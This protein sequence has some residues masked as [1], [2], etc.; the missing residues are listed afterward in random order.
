MTKPFSS[1]R[2]LTKPFKTPSIKQPP[3]PQL[4]ERLDTVEVEANGSED[5]IIEEGFYS[6][7]EVRPLACAEIGPSDQSQP[8]LCRC[9]CFDDF[10]DV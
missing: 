8:V 3:Q 1:A 7:A 2:G 4:R 9:S 5:I 6:P 10:V